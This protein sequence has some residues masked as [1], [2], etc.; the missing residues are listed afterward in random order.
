MISKS[1]E[2]ASSSKQEWQYGTVRKYGTVL[3][4]SI[5][6]KKYGTLVQYAF[7]AMVRVRYVDTVSFKN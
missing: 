2:V 1:V 6:A 4:A 3:Y 5:F 7:S